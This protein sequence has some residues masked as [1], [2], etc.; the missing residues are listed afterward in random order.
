[1]G[2]VEST[3]TQWSSRGGDQINLIMDVPISHHGK[4]GLVMGALVCFITMFTQKWREKRITL[5]FF[6]KNVEKFD[7]LFP[8]LTKNENKNSLEYV[9]LS[10]CSE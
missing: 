3:H 6:P 7:L 5:L 8:L 1:M 4:F 2:T 9:F 10:E